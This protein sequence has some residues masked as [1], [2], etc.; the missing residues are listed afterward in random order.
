MHN[1]DKKGREIFSVNLLQSA[2]Y[3][4]LFSVREAIEIS[5]NRD[6]SSLSTH[7]NQTQGPER[8]RHP[9]VLTEAGSEGP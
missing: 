4:E 1:L 7:L 3:R 2:F 6:R 9:G 8:E 5:L